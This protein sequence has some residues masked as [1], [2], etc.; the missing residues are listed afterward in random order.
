MGVAGITNESSAGTAAALGSSAWGSGRSS[1]SRAGSSGQLHAASI[2]LASV[3]RADADA[4]VAAFGFLPQQQQEQQEQQ[5]AAGGYTAH[6]HCDTGATAEDVAAED[7]AIAHAAE[8]PAIFY[9]KGALPAIQPHQHPQQQQQQHQIGAALPFAAGSS[10]G[11]LQQ[12][13]E[14]VSLDEAA[15]VGITAVFE[16]LIDTQQH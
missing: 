5:P 2:P 13:N 1:S 10:T 16:A 12:I 9:T 3:V 11:Q 14:M 8:Y 6:P 15:A 7:A 4:D